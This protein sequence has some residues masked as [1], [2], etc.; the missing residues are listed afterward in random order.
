ML[1]IYTAMVA[2]LSSSDGI[3]CCSSS[4]LVPAEKREKYAKRASKM[5]HK[6]FAGTKFKDVPVIAV[7]TKERVDG[8]VVHGT[9]M[10]DGA[11]CLGVQDLVNTMIQ[12]VP[13]INVQRKEDGDFM[14]YID[15][16]FSIKGQG[17]IVTGTLSEGCVSVGQS[18]EFPMMGLVRKVKSIQAFK[19]PVAR[20]IAGDRVGICVPNL[21]ATHIE[22]GLACK[23]GSMCTYTHAIVRVDKVRFFPSSIHSRKKLHILIGHSSVMATLEFFGMP[24]FSTRAWVQAANGDFA[25]ENDYIYQDELYGTEGRPISSEDWYQN[26]DWRLKDT[27]RAFVG[28]QWALVKFEEQVLARP[29]ALILGAKLDTDL[30]ACTCRIALSG[31]I[32]ANIEEKSRLRVFKIKSKEGTIRTV[33]PDRMTAVCSGLFASNNAVTTFL[34]MCVRGPDG[35]LGVIDS[36]YGTKG[37]CRVKFKEPVSIAGQEPAPVVLKFKQFLHGSDNG[38]KKREIEQ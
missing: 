29:G 4:D 11:Q 17:T 2:S 5:I 7:S 30:D 6:T 15:H 18:I 3:C 12:M 19:K 34:G 38:S 23:P 36:P 16:C 8:T 20:A 31:T 32:L 13:E 24:R 22:R 27:Q 14:M 25:W 9:M 1:R 21:S 26:S 37:D 33:E 35:N 10:T 28:P